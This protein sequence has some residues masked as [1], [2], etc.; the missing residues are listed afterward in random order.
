MN[1]R[2]EIEMLLQKDV[3]ARLPAPVHAVD[4]SAPLALAKSGTLRTA[5][6]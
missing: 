6:R 2:V 3:H 1:R 5:S 4:I